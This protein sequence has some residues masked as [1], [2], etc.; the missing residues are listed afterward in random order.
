MPLYACYTRPKLL[1][2]NTFTHIVQSINWVDVVM[3]VLLIRIVFIG[4]RTGF[5][6]EL[7]KLFGVFCSVFVGLHYYTPLA[8]LLAKK[9]DVSLGILECFFFVLLVSSMVLASNW[10]ESQSNL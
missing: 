8:A 6:T 3:L 4:V 7:F 9:V 1:E 2:M 10:A 5:V